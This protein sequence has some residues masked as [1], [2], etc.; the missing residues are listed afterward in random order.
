MGADYRDVLLERYRLMEEALREAL[1]GKR[2]FMDAELFGDGKREIVTLVRFV[3]NVVNGRV[4]AVAETQLRVEELLK[5]I[6]PGMDGTARLYIYTGDGTLMYASDEGDGDSYFDNAGE[7]GS[8]RTQVRTRKNG[9][10]EL[11]SLAIG[12]KYGFQVVYVSE[13]RISL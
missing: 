2:V 7:G 4:V 8:R 12:E 1:S 3:K 11:V 9:G 5:S 10:K 6:V 13:M